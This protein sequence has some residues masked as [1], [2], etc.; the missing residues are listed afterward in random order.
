MVEDSGM[1]V[2]EI[3][4]LTTLVAQSQMV[5]TQSELVGPRKVGYFMAQIAQSWILYGANRVENEVSCV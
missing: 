1:R 3:C 4:D 2:E 5:L